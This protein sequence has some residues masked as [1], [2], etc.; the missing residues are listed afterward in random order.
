MCM[1]ANTLLFAG[2]QRDAV[3]GQQMLHNSDKAGPHLLRKRLLPRWLLHCCRQA[4]HPSQLLQGL[5]WGRLWGKSRH[6]RGPGIMALCRCTHMAAWQLASAGL[7][8]G[9]TGPKMTPAALT[10]SKGRAQL[11]HVGCC[12]CRTLCNCHADTPLLHLPCRCH[13]TS[14]SLQ[15]LTSG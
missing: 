6:R 2:R 8:A 15:A 9:G 1:V 4:A 14:C 5:C 11:G 10:A 12:I 13:P 3:N 7:L